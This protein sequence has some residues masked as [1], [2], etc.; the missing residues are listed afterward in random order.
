[1]FV[2]YFCRQ[3]QQHKFITMYC[4]LYLHENIRKKESFYLIYSLDLLFLLLR[5]ASLFLYYI[6][7]SA[8][9]KTKLFTTVIYFLHMW[10]HINIYIYYSYFRRKK[11]ILSVL[12]MIATSITKGE[13]KLMSAFVQW[14]EPIIH[15]DLTTV[16]LTK[17][18]HANLHHIL[19]HFAASSS[20]S[21]ANINMHK[22]FD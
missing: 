5:S 16:S 18:M 7:C 15:Q 11:I 9:S 17:R 8:N 2:C 19:Q 10:G 14:H 22:R 4:I 12:L 6:L 20:L 3:Q 21:F 1:M 13:K